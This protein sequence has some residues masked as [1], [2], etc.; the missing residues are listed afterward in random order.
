[1]T[2]V[3]LY[4][5]TGKPSLRDSDG[6]VHEFY[7]GVDLS[8]VDLAI[9]ESLFHF[10]SGEWSLQLAYLNILFAEKDREK[11]PLSVNINQLPPVRVYTPNWAKK[12]TVPDET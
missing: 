8:G 7:C 11:R 3:S 9:V 5:P 6:N 1:M 12:D 2:H 4:D 10:K